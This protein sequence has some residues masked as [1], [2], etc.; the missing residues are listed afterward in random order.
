MAEYPLPTPIQMPEPSL[1]RQVRRGLR[2][3]GRL[4]RRAGPVLVRQAVTRHRDPAAVAAAMRI[5]CEELGATYVK[6]GQLVASAPG[7]VG[8]NVAEEFRNLLDRGPGVPFPRVKRTIERELDRP[9]AELYREFDPRPVAAASIAVVHRAVLHSGE[10]VAV[11]VLRPGIAETVSSDLDLMEPVMR[12]L[13][14]QGSDQAAVLYN[15]LIGLRAQIAEELDLRNE[16]L[17]MEYFRDLFQF[18]RLDKLAIPVVYPS[19]SSRRVIT[20]EFFDGV[21]I[22]DLARIEAI[23]MEPRPYVEELLRAW[24]LS[25]LLASVFH[26]DIHAGNLILL[27]EGKLGMVDWGI[28]ARLDDGTRDVMQGLVEASLGDE[29]AWER[30]TDF[31]NVLQ[32]GALQ[33]GLGLSDHE[34][35]L[36]VRNMLEPV[37]TQPI[38]DVSMAILFAGSDDMVRLARGK[39]PEHRGIMDRIRMN[40]R[41][42]KTNREAIRNGF[43][44]SPFRRANFLA[45]KQLVYLER[46][47]RMYMPDQAILGDHPFLEQVMERIRT[48]AAERSVAASN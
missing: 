40:R 35:Y 43:V 4:A 7:V 26:A 30:I 21:P 38:R 17:A 37:L 39:A 34:V 45:A 22:D 18:F 25:G 23:G 1:R 27:P 28:V 5:A 48:Q 10:V 9:L 33:E 19:H 13:A 6:F 46:Y 15:Y 41:V 8:D 32:G 29:T 47:A 16:A 20:M 14:E 24:I 36:L 12:F 2:T 44:E 31:M 42:A 3:G 11:K